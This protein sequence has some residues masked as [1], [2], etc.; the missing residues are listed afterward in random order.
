MP[1]KVKK[2]Y[3][4]PASLDSFRTQME[5]RYGDRVERHET[6]QEIL[7]VPTGVAGL[8]VALGGGW[9]LGR[10]HQVIGKPG[11]CKTA[12]VMIAL[13][14]AQKAYPDRQVGYIDMERTWTW[15]RATAMG[16]D[17]GKKR[18]LYVKPQ[19]S[20]E[21]SDILRDMLRSELFSLVGVDS[22]GSM[23]RAE[24]MYEKS[25]EE[26]DMGKNAQVI[27]RLCKQV[28]V[29]GNDSNTGTILVNQY[30]TDFAMGGDKAA[31]PM[32]MGYTTTDSVVM[33]RGFGAEDTTKIKDDDGQDIE[34]AHTVTARVERS[35]LRTAGGISKFWFNKVEFDGNPAGIDVAAE[36]FDIGVKT[37]ALVKGTGHYWVFPDGTKENGK[38]AA[39]RR[40]RNDPVALEAVRALSVKSVADEMTPE[41][42]VEFR[43]G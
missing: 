38:G 27:S 43:R 8:D 42:S 28:A 35:K 24:A 16:I 40:L 7:Y 31:G 21:V 39:I 32:I 13:A 6:A 3:T 34:V 33:R 29:I 1:P 30:R 20:E 14:N 19:S 5:K 17:T 25:A 4:P 10:M 36:A 18:L 2:T 12:M 37:E 23:E 26:S 11:C 15:E 41:A 9:A 22:I